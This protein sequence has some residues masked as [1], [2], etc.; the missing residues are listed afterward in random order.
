MKILFFIN[1]LANGGAE[2]T[3]S[4]LLNHLCEQHK[5]VLITFCQKKDSYIVNQSITRK[6]IATDCKSKIIRTINRIAKI[7]KEIKFEHPDL[8]ISFLTHTN[9]YVILANLFINKK[10]IVSEQTSI[11]N[12]DLKWRT[13]TTHILYKLATKVVL[14]THDDCINTYW[15]KN[16]KVIYNPLNFKNTQ[17]NEAREKTIATI[18]AQHSWHI[19]GLDLLIEA[20]TKIAFLHKDWRLQFIGLNDDSHIKEMVK[21]RDLQKQVEF[22]GWTNEPDKTLRTKSIYVLSSRREGFPCSLIEAMSQGCA[23]LA[24]DCKTGP[25][26]IITDGK[27]GLLALNGDIDDLANK[28]EM[29]INDEQLRH[30]LSAGAIEEVKRFDKNVFFAEWDKLIEKVTRK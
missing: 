14:T 22:L 24:F 16:K 11:Q 4:T 9:S 8:I 27:N 23:C 30:R 20:W 26:E 13:F 25:N 15:I 3:A 21:S 6:R 29:L 10:I 19:K 28:L 2:R 7:R 5:I 17:S 12:S 1:H 18:G